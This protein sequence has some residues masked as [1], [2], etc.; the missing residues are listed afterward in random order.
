M[1][2]YIA[3]P[4]DGG[5]IWSTRVTL[6]YS[7]ALRRLS[8][9]MPQLEVV[10]AGGETVRDEAGIPV[11]YST[12][13]VRARNRIAAQVLAKPPSD[14]VVL[15]WDDDVILNDM[16]VVDAMLALVRNGIDVLAAPYTSK[17]HP[18]RWTHQGCAGGDG[19][20]AETESVGFGFTMTTR[21]CLQKMADA[22]EIEE[23]LIDGVYH[24]VPAIFDLLKVPGRKRMR[25]LSEDYS[26]SAKWRGLGGK[27][28][29][30][31]RALIGH[32]GG[33][34]YDAREMR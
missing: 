15:W 33:H 6:G 23:D 25:R 8:L 28:Y 31:Q 20:I 7:E 1:T 5:D 19:V 11:Y 24:E 34:V 32:A 18:V 13:I 9:R 14:D 12:D 30:Y 21:A 26:F 4:I 22:S 16:N 27:L 17:R 2:L 29:V 3:T 10:R